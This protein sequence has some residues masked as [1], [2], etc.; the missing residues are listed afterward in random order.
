MKK[1]LI[2]F[3]FIFS[4]DIYADDLLIS[5]KINKVLPEGMSVQGVKES[6]I[7]N[8]YI[9][10]IGDL[11]P[12]YASADGEF[13]FYGEL[14]SVEGNT[15]QNTTKNE[16]NLKRKKILDN[17]LSKKDFISFISDT[18]KHV[19]TIFTDVDCGYCRKFHSEIDDFNDEGITVNYVAFPRSGLESDSYNKIVTAWCSNSPKETLTK[20]KQGIDIDLLMC[21]NHPVEKHYLLGQKIGI[22]GTPAIITSRGELLP[23]YLPPLELLKRLN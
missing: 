18:E 17:A 12:I 13:F 11:Q 21:Q 23:G 19:V 7:E 3:I 16:I 2:L 22:T 9:V 8:L 15:L 4:F 6:Q 20:M 1:L 10:D 5:S 14:Y